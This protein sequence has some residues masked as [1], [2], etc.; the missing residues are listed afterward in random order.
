VSTGK[1]LR[2][3]LGGTSDAGIRFDDLCSLLESLGFEKRS[4]GGHHVFR[5]AQVEEHINLQRSGN[6]AKPYQVKQVRTVI[7]KDKLGGDSDE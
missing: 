1:T 4:K 5:K 7:L 6:N 3:V 2:R